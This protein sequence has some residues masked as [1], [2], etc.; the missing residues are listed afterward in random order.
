MQRERCRLQGHPLGRVIAAASTALAISRR[1]LAALPSSSAA[2][3]AGMELLAALPRRG[4]A[5]SLLRPPG[6][7]STV[8]ATG[9]PAVGLT[10]ETSLAGDADSGGGG[11][12]GGWP[13]RGRGGGVWR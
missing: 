12:F 11:G 13:G 9:A 2:D 7:R 3:N 1:V 6:P 8:F 5:L 4:V 10:S